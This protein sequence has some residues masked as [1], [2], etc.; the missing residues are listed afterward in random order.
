MSAVRKKKKKPSNKER[1]ANLQLMFNAWLVSHAQA[2]V[3][4]LG[5]YIRHPINNLLT[6]AVIG[7]SLAL[8]A[9]FYV[10]LDNVRMVTSSWDG[11]LQVTLFLQNDISD[12]QATAIATRLDKDSRIESTIVIKRADALA[13]YKSLS[14]FADAIDAL[15]ENP[16]PAVIV[17]H[18]GVNHSAEADINALIKELEAMPEIDSAQYD[19]Q[20]I[21]RLL[22]ILELINRVVII[23]S[24]MLAAAVLLIVGNTIRLAIYNRRPEIEITK[25]FGGTDGFIQRP[26]L[27]SGLWY[28]VFGSLIAWCLITVSI[29]LLDQPVKELASLYASNFELIGLGI[30]NSLVLMA[31]GIALGLVG[32]WIAVKRHMRAIEPA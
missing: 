6:T 26:F 10:L 21:Q 22:Q 4:S 1:K 13:E 31:I 20:W 7:I 11:S 8:P 19:S 5:Q 28:G 14:G 16:L 23:L 29:T 9:S 18:P 32:S 27:Y 25:L 3:Y 17:A 30:R 24:T 15:D 12:Q 2:F